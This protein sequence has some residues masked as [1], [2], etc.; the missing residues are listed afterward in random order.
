MARGDKP[1]FRV[2]VAFVNSAEFLR[3][4]PEALKLYL[5]LSA[6]CIENRRPAVYHVDHSYLAAHTGLSYQRIPSALKELGFCLY[7]KEGQPLTYTEATTNQP[8]TN[9]DPTGSLLTIYVK[10]VERNNPNFKWSDSPLVPHSFPTR[11][12]LIVSEQNREE[13][14]TPSGQGEQVT[15]PALDDPKAKGSG[16]ELPPPPKP[17]RKPKKKP[18]GPHPET[19]DFFVTEYEKKYGVKYMF[20]GGKDGEAMSALLKAFSPEQ[21]R[22]MI[23]AYFQDT[24]PWLDGPPVKVRGLALFRSRANQYAAMLSQPVEPPRQQSGRLD[25]GDE[26]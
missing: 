25:L 13:T 21:I 18:V 19:I 17:E 1:Y 3:L 24:D 5:F 8:S 9:A 2:E 22:R 26:E 20:V 14:P 12:P 16:D 10:S 23:L 7:G 4:S 11:S 6:R 15:A